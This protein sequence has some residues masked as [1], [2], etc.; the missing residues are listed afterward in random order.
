MSGKSASRK[1][2]G[3]F[4]DAPDSGR[5]DSGIVFKIKQYLRKEWQIPSGQINIGHAVR[6][7]RGGCEMLGPLSRE[8]ISQAG[9]LIHTPDIIVTDKGGQPQLIIEQ[10]GRIHES[11]KQM[12][13]DR[14]RNGHYAYVGIPCIVLNTKEIRSARAIPAKYLD[15][16]MEKTGMTKP[17]GLNP[18]FFSGRS[19]IAPQAPHRDCP[20]S[21]AAEQALPYSMPAL[22]PSSPHITSFGDLGAPHDAVFQSFL[23]AP[24]C[25]ATVPHDASRAIRLAAHR[26]HQ[27]MSMPI[28]QHRMCQIRSTSGLAAE[29]GVAGWKR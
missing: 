25:P 11:E 27:G 28:W 10:D 1:R 21:A 12:K 29:C 24:M 8:E 19:E 18:L 2:R 22:K 20:A 9:G 15:R 13:K 5:P 16:K 3:R 14:A 23:N 4:R 7:T 26:A 17:V 6:I